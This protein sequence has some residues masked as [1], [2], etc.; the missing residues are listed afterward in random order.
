MIDHG[1]REQRNATLMTSRNPILENNDRRIASSIRSRD[2]LQF[3]AIFRTGFFANSTGITEIRPKKELIGLLSSVL[4][5][6]QRFFLTIHRT[7]TTTRTLLFM[8]GG[9]E[10]VP[11]PN[12]L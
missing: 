9:A 11:G 3:Q 7:E 1:L 10:I 5:N 2:R 4:G 12:S 8:N 6:G